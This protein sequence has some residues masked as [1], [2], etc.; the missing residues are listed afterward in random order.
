MYEYWISLGTGIGFIQI[1]IRVMSEVAVRGM[2]SDV[3]CHRGILG[4]PGDGY[5]QDLQPNSQFWNTK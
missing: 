3:V 5:F 2:T 4:L 1:P